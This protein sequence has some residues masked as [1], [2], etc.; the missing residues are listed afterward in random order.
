MISPFNKYQSIEDIQPDLKS[1]D[2]IVYPICDNILFVARKCL[3]PIDN[4]YIVYDKNLATVVGLFHKQIQLFS[5]FYD[6][7]KKRKMYMCLILQR[8]IYEAYIKM[9]FLIKHGEKAQ[10][11]YRLCSYKARKSFYEDS[12]DVHNGY[13]S[14]RNNK[15]T[16]DLKDDGFELNDLSKSKKSFGG[17][18]FKQLMEEIEDNKS[19]Y[20]SLY[21]LVSDSIHS[22]WGDL[23]QIYLKKTPDNDYVAMLDK[24]PT[25]HYRYLIPMAS[26]LIDSCEHFVNREH[27]YDLNRAFLPLLKE[28][29]RVCELIMM[30]VFTDYQNNPDKYMLE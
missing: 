6:S 16:L 3:N 21:G 9:L 10:I 15:F 23:R 1:E 30:S 27:G 14:V 8:I 17:K 7:Y 11:E 2:V 4:D 26:L 19:L 5:E 24:I 28:L 20:S 29:H 13:I 25:G 18:S 22:D 12:H